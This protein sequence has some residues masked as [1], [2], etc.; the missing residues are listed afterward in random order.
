MF[1][2][3][4]GERRVPRRCR[5]SAWRSSA[6]SSAILA[7]LRRRLGGPFTIDELVDLYDQGTGWCT[8]IA[9]ARRAGRAVG[10]GRRGRSPTPPSR[11][12]VREATDYAGGRRLTAPGR[13]RPRSQRR[14][15]WH[16][17]AQIRPSTPTGA[18]PSRA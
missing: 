18:K 15:G 17:E 2:W 4:E 6:S 5:T 10:V 9:Y 16:G 7:E 14:A 8:D 11:R 13:L 1:Q 12:Y 3:R